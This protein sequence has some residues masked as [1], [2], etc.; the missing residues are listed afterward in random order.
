MVSLDGAR[1]MD[2]QEVVADTVALVLCDRPYGAED[3]IRGHADF[4]AWRNQGE[5]QGKR[6]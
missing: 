3:H 6:A 5:G 1:I 2:L 4:R